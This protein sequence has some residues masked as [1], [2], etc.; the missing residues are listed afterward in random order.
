MRYAPLNCLR[1][2]EEP[3]AF[4]VATPLGPGLSGDK[5]DDPL[6]VTLTDELH[7]CLFIQGKHQCLGFGVPASSQA[8]RTPGSCFT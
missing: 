2:V 5:S 8:S 6:A 7:T 4:V 1:G 3:L